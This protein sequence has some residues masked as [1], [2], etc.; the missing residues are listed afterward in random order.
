MITEL[1]D[2]DFP[3]VY[4][5]LLRI[6]PDKPW[7]KIVRGLEQNRAQEPFRAV[8]NEWDQVIPCGLTAWEKYGFCPPT[9]EVGKTINE[10]MLT[11]VQVAVSY[12]HLTLPTICS[13]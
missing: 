3:G 5:R 13:V 7:K 4:N 1:Y 11:A 6:F 8:V 2:I 9:P 10:A 12:T